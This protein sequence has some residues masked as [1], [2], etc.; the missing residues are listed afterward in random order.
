M[1]P[2]ALMKRK[3]AVVSGSEWQTDNRVFLLDFARADRLITSNGRFNRIDEANGDTTRYL[4][5][6]DSAYAPAATTL[7]GRVFAD[8]RNRDRDL[9]FAGSAQ[10]SDDFR[11]LYGPAT[12]TCV[13]IPPPST[14]THDSPIWSLSGYRS[15]LNQLSLLHTPSDDLYIPRQDS[16]TCYDLYVGR[17]SGFAW[18]P[19]AT[20]VISVILT[21]DGS[22]RVRVNGQ[23]WTVGTP[24][25]YAVV[26][27]PGAYATD[28][29]FELGYQNNYYGTNSGEGLVGMVAKYNTI[30]TATQLDALNTVRQSRY[31]SSG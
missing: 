16:N 19:N 28:C 30:L 21:A 8:Y 5:Q 18:N 14:P 4:S 7:F 15:D 13:Y 29:S 22:A 23:E 31:P 24:T 6:G 27:P 11:D 1:F 10:I 12:Y 20:Y 3:T 9:G 2:G 17:P 26:A 25:D